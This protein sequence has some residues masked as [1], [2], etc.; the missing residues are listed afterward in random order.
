MTWDIEFTDEFELWWNSLEVE[1]QSALGDVVDVLEAR[2]P[3]LGRPYVDTIHGSRH[4]NMKELRIGST[5]I[6]FAFDPRRTA[7]L[8]LGGDKRDRWNAWYAEM[9]PVA[10]RLYDH[11]LNTLRAEGEL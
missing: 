8:L 5:R 4:P 7:I 10:D 11:H 6:L 1:E 9:I 2:G 3:G